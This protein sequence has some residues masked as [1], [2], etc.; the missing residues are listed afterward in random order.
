MEVFELPDIIELDEF[1]GDFES[2]YEAVYQIFRKDF[3]DSKPQYR[4][5]KLRL[6]RHPLIDGKEYTFY[7]MTHKGDIE[8]DREPDLR[9]MERIPWPRPMIDNSEHSYLKVWR[10]TRRGKG[11]KKER[12]LI[13]HEQESYLMI[14]EDRKE[15]I[16]PWTAYP[17]E[18][19]NK[20]RRLLKE[21]EE[22]QN[23]N[24][25]R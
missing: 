19:R 6:K 9:R 5:K 24:R 16:L 1:G 25:S 8:H 20:K 12:I 18:Y 17:V 4:G 21:Y 2:F 14:L 3:V 11:G 22:Y 23:K 10:N 7:H 13:F 15:Y